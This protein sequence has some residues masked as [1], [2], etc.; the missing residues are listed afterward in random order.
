[1]DRNTHNKRTRTVHLH[2]SQVPAPLRFDN[3]LPDERDKYTALIF[4]FLSEERNKASYRSNPSAQP[5]YRHYTSIPCRLTSALSHHTP[6]R[7]LSSL[8]RNSSAFLALYGALAC[9]SPTSLS[10]RDRS[11]GGS[12]SSRRRRNSG[13]CSFCC[14]CSG[15][16]HM[17]GRYVGW[18]EKWMPI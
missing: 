13:G 9:A 10:S 14:R 7:V 4:F 5:I 18:D 15:C 2:I 1:M 11:G 17:I 12:S 3:R 6:Y 16:Q 8:D